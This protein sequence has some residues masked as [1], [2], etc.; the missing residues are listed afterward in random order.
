MKITFS[1]F[2]TILLLGFIIEFGFAIAQPISK[3][4]KVLTIRSCDE[5]RVDQNVIVAKGIGK[6]PTFSVSSAQAKLMARRAAIVVAQRNLAKVVG[7]VIKESKG[8]VSRTKVKAFLRGFR[9]REIRELPNGCIE[10]TLELPL[11]G[12]S[13]LATTLGYDK[14]VVH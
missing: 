1:A 10:A 12:K 4:E 9:I 3:V 7:K 13:S 8:Q 11:N 2:I 5:I 14:I 6:P